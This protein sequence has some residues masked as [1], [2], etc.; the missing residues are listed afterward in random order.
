MH[1]DE[2]SLQLASLS[3]DEQLFTLCKQ[4]KSFAHVQQFFES[5]KV[6]A[7]WPVVPARQTC[8]PLIVLQGVS[9]AQYWFGC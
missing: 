7:G 1:S 8:S 4:V 9:S 5:M 2:T 3:K 6:D